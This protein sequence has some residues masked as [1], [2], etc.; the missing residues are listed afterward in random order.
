MGL[1][2]NISP[3]TPGYHNI[4][5][6]SIRTNVY[7]QLI[8][9]RQALMTVKPMFVTFKL[10]MH[11]LC[12]YRL[13]R[14]SF[15]S[16]KVVILETFAFKKYFLNC[17]TIATCTFWWIF[18]KYKKISF[19]RVHKKTLDPI[20]KYILKSWVF[21]MVVTT[22]YELKIPWNFSLTVSTEDK[23][24]PRKI[25]WLT[26]PEFSEVTIGRDLT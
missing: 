14:K 5:R 17:F 2:F 25:P 11:C 18:F 22:I 7:V 24:Y 3:I 1:N 13:Q 21:E 9:N 4:L 26:F 20:S 16:Y 19:V 8:T 23:W 6:A 12:L 15:V 10:D